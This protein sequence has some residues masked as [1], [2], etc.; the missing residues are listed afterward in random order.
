VGTLG[1]INSFKLQ[2]S[3]S[4]I[5][6]NPLLTFGRDIQY[7]QLKLAHLNVII[8]SH[9]LCSLI[10]PVKYLSEKTQEYTANPDVV[11]KEN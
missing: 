8:F 4:G 2:Q 3:Q 11:L 10:G 7:V 5:C 6:H 1:R 9:S